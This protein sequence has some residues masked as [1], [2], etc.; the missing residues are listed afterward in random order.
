MGEEE[1]EVETT[2]TFETKVSFVG[3]PC[4]SEEAVA[5]LDAHCPEDQPPQDEPR[6][7]CLNSGF[8][9]WLCHHKTLP[10]YPFNTL[11]GKY[12]H[13]YCLL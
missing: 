5:K 13:W 6:C 8:L 7:L 3:P 4:H 2:S 11:P 1:T 9:P 10:R 12:Q